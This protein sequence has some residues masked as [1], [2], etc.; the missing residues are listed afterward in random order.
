VHHD[1]ASDDAADIALVVVVQLHELVGQRIKRFDDELR[2]EAVLLGEFA[3]RAGVAA[4][5]RVGDLV[6]AF[7]E[8]GPAGEVF[9][10]DAD[11]NPVAGR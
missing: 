10:V 2:D 4:Q 8:Q 11:G 6:A 1:L 5:E 3:D 7:D 9:V